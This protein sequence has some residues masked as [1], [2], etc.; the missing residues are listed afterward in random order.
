MPRMPAQVRFSRSL[1]C[2]VMDGQPLHVLRPIR[3]AALQWLDVVG[4]VA[5]ARP[6]RR[7]RCRAGMAALEL[8]AHRA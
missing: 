2:M 4:L 1:Q 5:R 8:G 7:I 6:S 3:A